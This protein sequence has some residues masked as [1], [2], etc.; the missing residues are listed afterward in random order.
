MRRKLEVRCGK[1]N[2][3]LFYNNNYSKHKGMCD[4]RNIRFICETK[5][6]E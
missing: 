1:K 3:C 4:K 2:I 5:N 6:L